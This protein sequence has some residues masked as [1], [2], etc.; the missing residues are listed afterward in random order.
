MSAI[1][2][3]CTTNQY[4][5]ATGLGGGCCDNGQICTVL[6]N[7]NYCALAT[8]TNVLTR[9]GPGGVLATL[10][11]ADQG[12]SKALSTGAKAGIGV[13]VSLG[14]LAIIGIFLYFCLVHRRNAQRS[15]SASQPTASQTATS[16]VAGSQVAGSQVAG[17]AI[18]N[19]SNAGSKTRSKA[20]SNRPAPGRQASQP[21]DYFGPAATAGPFTEEGNHTS[22]ATSPGYRTAQGSPG[23]ERGV[24]VIPQSPG[25]IVTPVEIDSREQSNVNSPSQFV[26][27]NPTRTQPPPRQERL[28]ETMEHRVEL[29]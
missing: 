14:A 8:G 24:A 10:V 21:S 28:Q 16:Q 27:T 18:L 3:G 25:D 9:T 26:N 6:S 1:P 17:S 23:Y 15:Q 2:S 12:G 22:Q 4:A 19:G 13:G 20:G 5:C 11:P 29:P 7:T